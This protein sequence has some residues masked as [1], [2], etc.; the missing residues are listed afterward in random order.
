MNQIKTV[1]LMAALGALLVAIGGYMGGKSGATIALVIAIAMN[2]GSYWFSDKIVLRM[3][4]AQEVTES[5]APDLYHLVSQL[6]A[7][8]AYLCR[9]CISFLTIHQTPSLPVATPA[10]PLSQ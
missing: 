7:K 1:L 4:N 10:T 3:Y 6:V 9:R 5:E 2:F 8:Q